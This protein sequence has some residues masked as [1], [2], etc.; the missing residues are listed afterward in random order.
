[1]A[2][3]GDGHPA[4][5]RHLGQRGPQRR[6]FAL[7][8]MLDHVLRCARIQRQVFGDAAG[9]TGIEGCGYVA[10]WR[11]FGGDASVGPGGELEPGDVPVDGV[12]A[13]VAGPVFG[14]RDPYDAFCGLVGGSRE[15]PW[16]YVRVRRPG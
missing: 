3:L 6:G 2:D 8:V 11:E 1:L 7:D 16:G 15:R 12:G 13:D 10:G 5:R 14:D 9:E 4:S